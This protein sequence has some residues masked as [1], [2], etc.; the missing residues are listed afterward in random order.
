MPNSYA[1]WTT[2]PMGLLLSVKKGGRFERGLEAIADT[3]AGGSAEC[4]EHLE[5]KW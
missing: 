5:P 3:V 1:P 4:S 2:Y